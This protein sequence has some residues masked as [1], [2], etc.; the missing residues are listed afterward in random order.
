MTVA[1]L[2][3]LSAR[4]MTGAV[5]VGLFA[6]SMTVAVLIRRSALYQLSDSWKNKARLFLSTGPG[7]VTIET[8]KYCG[9]HTHR[10]PLEPSLH[11]SCPSLAQPSGTRPTHLDPKRPHSPGRPLD[12][13]VDNA[14]MTREAGIDSEERNRRRNHAHTS[15][16]PGDLEALRHARAL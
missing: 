16:M 2:I 12:T 1:V 9:E 8:T 14:S 3:G 4:F 15:D 13:T 7:R 10:N 5:L 11:C 6:R